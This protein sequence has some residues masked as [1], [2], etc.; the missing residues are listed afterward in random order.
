VH[1]FVTPDQVDRREEEDF[2]RK[3]KNAAGT[4]SGKAINRGLLRDQA[5]EKLPWRSW[6]AALRLPQPGHG[7]PNTVLKR[8]GG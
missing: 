4:A 5:A 1:V 8:H 6:W 7:A 3:V 2:L